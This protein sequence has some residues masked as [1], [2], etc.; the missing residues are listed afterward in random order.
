VNYRTLILT[1]V[2][3]LAATAAFGG[4]TTAG[5][6]HQ[7][8]MPLFV[9]LDGDGLNDNIPDLNNDGIPDFGKSYSQPRGSALSAS[10]SG[11]FEQMPVVGNVKPMASVS[12]A[13]RFRALKFCARSL[14]R[15]RDGFISSD[16]SITDYAVGQSALS[17]SCAG[18]ICHP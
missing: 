13:D 8:D 4:E 5:K 3:V 16:E 11:V 1:A 10:V 17:G 9:D 18:G 12:N 6:S 15:C 14:L 7:S 2:L